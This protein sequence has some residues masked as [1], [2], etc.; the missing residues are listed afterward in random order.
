MNKLLYIVLVAVLLASCNSDDNI[1]DE[2]SAARSS[3][4]LKDCKTTLTSSEFGWKMTYSPKDGVYGAYNYIM[5]FVGDSVN[6]ACD[7]L[8]DSTYSKWSMNMGQ[9][10]VLTFD[11]YGYLHLLADPQYV[12]SGY[13]LEGDFEF[14]VTSVSATELKLMSKKRGT[15][16]S[17]IK[18][19][20]DDWTSIRTMRAIQSSLNLAQYESVTLTING[21]NF[22]YPTISFNFTTHV[23][24][25][26]YRNA[27]G[28]TVTL[29]SPYSLNTEGCTLKAPIKMEDVTVEGFKVVK[30]VS[31]PNIRKLVSTD[32]ANA[33]VL[34]IVKDSPLA[35][36]AADIPTYV[37]NPSIKSVELMR[38]SYKTYKV[39]MMSASLQAI[40]NAIK[41]DLPNFAGFWLHID[42]NATNPGSMSFSA[43]ETDGEKF[44]WYGFDQYT[45]LNSSNNSVYFN[46]LATGGTAGNQYTSGWTGRTVYTGHSKMS[47][48]RT[49]FFFNLAGHTVIYDY[50]DTYWI[51]SNANP[52][53]W[54][55]IEAVK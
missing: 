33:V 11:T 50:Y 29:T 49:Q 3:K 32:A 45:M 27:G 46:K 52:N 18:A 48:M 34:T 47:E 30:D 17:L 21:V 4:Y 26:T 8:P 40:A 6:I 24:K 12:T 10:P 9:G 42:R 35:L 25:L 54:W 19:T 5:K 44:Y 41:T 28:T 55:K 38:N 16:L 43:K 31:N 22:A 7:L 20:A 39:T 1:F 53:D 37:P 51:R 23:C 2:S 15:E 13:G 14:I 36:K